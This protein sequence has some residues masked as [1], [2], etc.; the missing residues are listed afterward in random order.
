MPHSARHQQRKPE[1]PVTY[2]SAADR[3]P[4]RW[5][6]AVIGL[7]VI[8]LAMVWT[9]F[10]TQAAR[11]TDKTIAGW[12]EREAALGR[13]YS[14]GTQTV[15]GFPFR[16]VVRCNDATAELRNVRTPLSLKLKSVHI[17]AQVYQPTLLISE[18]A[19]P[20]TLMESGEA[21]SFAGDWTS[22]RASVRGLPTSP[23]R[24]SVVFD[25]P[26]V[27]RVADARATMFAAKHAEL[28]GRIAS[29]SI[30][31]N[32]VLE[33][34]V[35][36]VAAT[37][38]NTY[39]LLADPLDADVDT[40]LHGLRDFSP[41]PWPV[42]FRDLQ[43]AGGRIEIRSARVRQGE[44]VAIGAGVLGLTP[45]GRLDGQIRLTVAGLEKVLPALGVERLAPPG[46]AVDQLAGLLNR[47]MP[48]L[49][50]VA[51]D[52]AGVGIAYG[53]NA[54]GQPTELE[55]KPAVSLP[56]R[57]VDGAA[58]LGPLPLGEIRPLF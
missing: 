19:G 28:H 17:L 12:R 13:H 39:P 46:G 50:N 47:V 16:I 22:A 23:E 38:P 42:V 53:I 37:A 33:I 10:W 51:R 27:E 29:G 32:P 41:K 49:G 30:T 5:P 6:L 48:G 24:I 26:R 18:F 31:E 11:E 15:G 52:N 45:Q 54:L 21:Q 35:N 40:V 36:L 55:G 56:L 43:A 25:D 2:E 4:R 20:V 44:A 57:F 1:P 7:V 3:R 58:F 34:A 8:A 14:C 9:A